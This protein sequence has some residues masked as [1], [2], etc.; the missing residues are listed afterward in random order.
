MKKV[1]SLAD[2]KRMALA[3]GASLEVGNDHFNTTQERVHARMQPV[4]PEPKPEPP[5]KPEPA[6]IQVE[7]Y[8]GVAPQ[9]V[10]DRQP[11]TEQITVHLDM[12]PVAQAI[13]GNNERLVEVLAEGIR[14][15]PVAPQQ[16]KPHSWVFKIKR[17]TRGFIESVEANVKPGD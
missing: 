14:Q 8:A 5:P 9:V 3:K 2:L 11:V 17:D 6:P 10:F 12:G 15:L 16:T 7:P 1:K 13:E 4:E